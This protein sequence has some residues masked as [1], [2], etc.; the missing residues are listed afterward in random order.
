MFLQRRFLCLLY[1]AA[2]GGG[3]GVKAV[4]QR[5]LARL[6]L[7]PAG[8]RTFAL[9]SDLAETLLA[10]AQR[11]GRP[12]GELIDELL[13]HGLAQSDLNEHAWRRWSALSP[14][15]QEV[16]A[17]A[18]LGCTNRQI[19]AR[20]GISPGTV[21]THVR[22]ILRRFELHSKDELR[23]LLQDWDF[24]AWGDWRGGR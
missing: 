16:A 18:C 2:N 8:R 11:Q 12:A 15:E 13:A 19:A 23:S 3:A 14:R 7:R 6:G 22:N 4:L 10:L 17:L 9:T 20:L 21:K 1:R 24:S 5:L